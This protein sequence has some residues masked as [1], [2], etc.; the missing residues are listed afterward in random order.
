MVY[1]LV[2]APKRLDTFARDR[3][4]FLCCFVCVACAQAGEKCRACL[5]NN[6]RDELASGGIAADVVMDTP[7]SIPAMCEEA[8]RRV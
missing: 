4:F 2:L 8:F 7:Y 6:M 3:C 1:I 5:A